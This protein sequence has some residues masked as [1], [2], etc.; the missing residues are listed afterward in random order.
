VAD[1]AREALKT[2]L[3]ALLKALTAWRLHKM[4]QAF[5]AAAA[6]SPERASSPGR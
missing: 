6:G 3:I 4:W 2:R 5:M 1:A